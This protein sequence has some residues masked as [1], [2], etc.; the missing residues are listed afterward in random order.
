MRK[1]NLSFLM[2]AVALI[3]SLAVVNRQAQ[4]TE[5]YFGELDPLIVRAER[6]D[7]RL[8]AATSAFYA[9]SREPGF[10]LAASQENFD[11][12]LVEFEDTNDLIRT[13][14]VP[15]H[16]MEHHLLVRRLVEA[17]ERHAVA[18]VNWCYAIYDLWECAGMA[19][20]GKASKADVQERLRLVDKES[21]EQHRIRER[22]DSYSR[23]VKVS[24]L[25][26][27][28]KKRDRTESQ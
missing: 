10:D 12:L 1:L 3:A 20:Q 9:P 7:S 18:S 28:A 6:I 4:Q 21:R 26:F 27:E 5:S 23:A 2:I 19:E 24:R 16:L 17:K 15:E 25:G 14:P 8:D 13:M 22:L 11:S